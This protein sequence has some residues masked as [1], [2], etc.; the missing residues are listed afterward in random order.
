MTGM[1]MTVLC[2][3]AAGRRCIANY[4]EVVLPSS[5]PQAAAWHTQAMILL[6]CRLTW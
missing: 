1:L 2:S 6:Y 5:L 4:V 3:S